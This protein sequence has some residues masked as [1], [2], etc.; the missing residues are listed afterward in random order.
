MS[1]VHLAVERRQVE[2]KNPCRR[3]RKAGK[4]PAVLYGGEGAP[5]SIQIDRSEL[6]ALLRTG[7]GE[8]TIFLLKV[9]GTKDERHAMIKEMQV[10][11]VRR[12]VLHLD[13]QRISMSES[14][15]VK[16]EVE[17]VGTPVGVKVEGGIVDFVTR[18]IEIECLP[19]RIPETLKVD[20]SGLHIGMHV[21]ASS[22][23]LPEGVTLIDDPDR[24]L[25][26]VAAPQAPAAEEE[27]G[28][29]ELLEGERQEPKLV[30]EDDEDED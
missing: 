18:E 3:L 9:P 19:N 12:S 23:E 29:D 16:V 26:L 30:G 14:V 7:S 22:I 8:N 21:E 24:V 20:V 2:G 17:L 11:P 6:L 5:V 10:D 28:A 27:E 4:I 25:A 13:F 15:Q 1:E